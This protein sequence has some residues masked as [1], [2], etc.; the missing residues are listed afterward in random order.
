M[1]YL[2][3]TLSSQIKKYLTNIEYH[4]TNYLLFLYCY[5]RYY[6]KKGAMTGQKPTNKE[7]LFNLCHSSVWNVI[8]KIFVVIKRQFQILETSIEFTIEVKVKIILAVTGLY[9]FIQLHCTIGDIY[10]KA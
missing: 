4:N 1:Y 7:E 5:I 9:N 3:K 2:K 8:E 6:Q 10:D